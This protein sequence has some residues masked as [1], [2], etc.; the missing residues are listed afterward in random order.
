MAA[1]KE[2]YQ[3][4]PA[5]FIC[6]F[7]SAITL[8]QAIIIGG[9]VADVLIKFTDALFI[10]GTTLLSVKLARD[11]DEMPAAGFI[12][13]AIGWGVLFASTDFMNQKVGVHIVSSAFYFV[14]PAMILMTFYKKFKLWLRILLILNI[15]PFQ[16]SM[17][18]EMFNPESEHILY[19][20]YANILFM[21]IVSIIWSIFFFIQYKKEKRRLTNNV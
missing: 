4:I 11:G 5:Q 12:L 7:G 20:S 13:L 3:L 10:T 9:H 17:V 19:W 1:H 6:F 14:F 21:H 18:L 15:V 8:I 16:V 2:D